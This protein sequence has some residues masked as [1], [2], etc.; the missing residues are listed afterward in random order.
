MKKLLLTLLLMASVC[1][2]DTLKILYGLS[3]SEG[4]S[5]DT[6]RIIETYGNIT[7]TLATWHDGDSTDGIT[8]IDTFVTVSGTGLHTVYLK[9]VYDGYPNEMYTIE[10]WE[11]TLSTAAELSGG[12]S[13]TATIHAVDSAGTDS[14]VAGIPI[15]VK[16]LTGST[17]GFITTNSSG[18]AVFNLDSGSYDISAPLGYGYIWLRDTILVNAAALTDTLWGYNVVIGTP[19]AANLCR[20]YDNVHDLNGNPIQ[21]VQVEATL[22]SSQNVRDSCSNVSLSGYRVTAVS[23]T[24]GYWYL[25]LIKTLCIESTTGSSSTI[26]YQIKATYPSGTEL[27]DKRYTVPDSTTHRMI[28]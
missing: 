22:V 15:T 14:G 26:K 25:D 5:L 8:V 2:A 3:P 28:W 1:G 18:Y 12:G 19:G 16:N 20:L 17:N 4:Y 23:D 24:S 9:G 27:V 13:Y 7:D 10:K 6:A 11:L 21:G